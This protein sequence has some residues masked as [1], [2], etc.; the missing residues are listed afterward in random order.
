MF[1]L[2]TLPLARPAQAKI[3]MLTGEEIGDSY[4][5]YCEVD[6]LKPSKSE[7]SLHSIASWLLW[8]EI[9]Y[10]VQI[11]QSKRSINHFTPVEQSRNMC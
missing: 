10:T 5:Q 4:L 9:Q 2:Y 7:S 6:S 11:A 3:Q 8:I 1:C